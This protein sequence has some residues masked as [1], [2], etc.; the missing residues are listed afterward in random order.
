MPGSGKIFALLVASADVDDVCQCMSSTDM[1][2]EIVT[3]P[4]VLCC[5]SNDSW[6]VCHCEL[7]IGIADG[8]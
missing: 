7:E 5:T 8:A 4:L 1:P 6:D 3:Q 2:Q